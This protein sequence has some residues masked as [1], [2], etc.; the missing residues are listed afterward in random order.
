MSQLTEFAIDVPLGALL[1]E[2]Y[3]LSDDLTAN[4]PRVL[5]LS[6]DRVQINWQKAQSA[7]TE[8]KPEPEPLQTGAEQTIIDLQFSARPSAPASITIKPKEQNL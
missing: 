7:S 2:I 3:Q 5:L 6:G 4:Q 8:S 1:Q